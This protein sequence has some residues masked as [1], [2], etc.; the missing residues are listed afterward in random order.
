MT[1]AV[2]DAFAHERLAARQANVLEPHFGSNLDDGFYLFQSQ[3][4][5]VRKR[6]HAFFRHA[7]D[8]PQVAAV[9]ERNPQVV[10]SPSVG[11]LHKAPFV[12]V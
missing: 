4:V 1:N 10:Y 7:V 5:L 6:A 8:A 2:H 3:D 12:L 9:G 11:I